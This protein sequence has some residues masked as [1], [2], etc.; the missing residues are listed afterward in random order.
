[1]VLS[2]MESAGVLLV[3]D[4]RSLLDSASLLLRMAGIEP[5]A[6][7]DDS[8]AVLPWLAGH[9]V[10][11]VLLD[12]TMPHLGGE[13]LLE[14]IAQEH[15]EVPVIVVTAT[16]DL[17]TAVRCMQAGAIDYLLKP[18]EPA[19]LVSAVQRGL[20]MRALRA[21]VRRLGDS[22]LAP[23]PGRHPAFAGIVTQSALMA[24]IFRYVEAVARSANPVLITGESGTGKEQIAEAIHA[25]SGR[26]GEFVADAV[27]GIDDTLFSD[28]LFG[29][30]RG[31][32][33][34]ADRAL[35]GLVSRAARG[36]LF[37]DEIGD[38]TPASQVKLLRLLQNGEYFALGTDRP[39]RSQARIVAATHFDLAAEIDAK[40][41]RRDLFF[42]L[43][44]HH[45]HLP[46]LRERVG[47]LPLLVRL[48][49][50]QAAQRYDKPVPTVP[51]ALLQLLGA[52]DWPGNIRQ[53]QGMCDDAVLRHE[54]G[55][56]SMQSFRAKMGEIAPAAPA[57]TADA[58][59]GWP[60][61]ALPTLDDADE[62]LIAE[63][64]RR[65]E[66]NQ[67]VAAGM[68]GL[69]RQALN[70]RLSRRRGG[71]GDGGLP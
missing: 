22:L 2:A 50:E 3:D 27:G 24:P 32:F 8:R 37:L 54:G 5:V 53:L 61:G 69:S 56:L 33:S 65:A 29:H 66:G 9:A 55:V 68:L 17:Q 36:T 35:P 14:K 58:E 62:A 57:A 15:P 13:A 47:D 6:L 44:T 25:L 49:V 67:G 46:P 20:E 21:D 71:G 16:A 38:L 23:S 19:R 12:L 43:G 52:Y 11:L 48:F 30:V 51:P 10:G 45:V 4:E 7:L 28:R 60:A 1:M 39:Q 42:R 31:A 34:G 26:D 70:K 41:F 63:A 40:R 18:V 59:I 64:L